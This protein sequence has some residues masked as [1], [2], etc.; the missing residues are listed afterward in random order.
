MVDLLLDL[1]FLKVELSLQYSG[2]F[3]M[4]AVL[5]NLPNP[6]SY[7]LVHGAKFHFRSKLPDRLQRLNGLL[8]SVSHRLFSWPAMQLT[9]VNVSPS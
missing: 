3:F 9:T 8:V 2:P 6:P 7:R 5:P 1:I 4:R